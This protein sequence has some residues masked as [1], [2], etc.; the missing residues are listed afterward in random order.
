LKRD[1]SGRLA[2]RAQTGTTAPPERAWAEYRLADGAAIL[3]DP[4]VEP[5]VSEVGSSRPGTAQ[6]KLVPRRAGQAIRGGAWVFLILA[7]IQLAG[8][9]SDVSNWGSQY[10]PI[11]YLEMLGNLAAI[12]LPA[13]ILLWRP[14]AWRSNRPLILGAALWTA[15]QFVEYLL[16]RAAIMLSVDNGLVT[17]IMWSMPVVDG[18]LAIAGGL[19]LLVGLERLHAKPS[20]WPRPLLFAALALTAY[21][22][23]TGLQHMAEQD[24]YTGWTIGHVRWWL[25][26]IVNNI[27]GYADCL[28][29]GGFLWSALSAVRAGDRPR[30]LWWP[31]LVAS[32]SPFF[33]TGGL[34]DVMALTGF[35]PN[36]FDNPVWDA[37]SIVE[38]ASAVLMTA[39]FV[40]PAV[41]GESNA[42][43]VAPQVDLAG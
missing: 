35:Q 41:L 1:Y 32:I 17:Q 25:N 19:L 38:S 9:Y 15:P 31:F 42:S 16:N 11:T 37:I 26:A 27:R 28:W 40:L 30:S 33:I 39:A 21:L 13:A 36:W 14:D 34:Y 4:A 22:C 12:L 43:R 6:L 29:L 10:Q 2:T 20:R 18:F 5:P 8:D 7:G 3:L 24:L 23:V